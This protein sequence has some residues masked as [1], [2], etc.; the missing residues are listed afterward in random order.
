MRR[1]R[2][3]GSRQW[4]RLR[5]KALARDGYRC[6]RCGAPGRLEVH[7]VIPVERGGGDD[8]ANLMTRCR[9]CHLADHREDRLRRMAPDRRAWAEYMERREGGA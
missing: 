9:G 6:T 5:R 8:L 1:S 3:I 2:G 4:G 7:H